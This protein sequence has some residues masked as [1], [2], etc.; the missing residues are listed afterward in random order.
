MVDSYVV[1]SYHK[2]EISLGPRDYLVDQTPPLRRVAW[3]GAGNT[4]LPSLLPDEEMGRLWRLADAT[5]RW[6]AQ[7]KTHK[8]TEPRVVRY[9]DTRQEWHTKA[10]V[11]A[12]PQRHPTP[13]PTTPLAL[14]RVL[15]NGTLELPMGQILDH[16]QQ[17]AEGHS[18][19]HPYLSSG[20]RNIV[21]DTNLP[22]EQFGIYTSRHR[23]DQREDY[24][25]RHLDR[26]GLGAKGPKDTYLFYKFLGVAP[27]PYVVTPVV[28]LMPSHHRPW[29]ALIDR[30]GSY[31]WTIG[32]VWLPLGHL[33]RPRDCPGSLGTDAP[34]LLDRD[35]RD[36]ICAAL[37]S[38][39]GESLVHH[40]T[41]LAE[42][43]YAHPEQ[44]S[45]AQW[46]RLQYETQALLTERL[47]AIY[48]PF[49]RKYKPSDKVE[50]WDLPCTKSLVPPQYQATDDYP[51]ATPAT[52]SQ[53]TPTQSTRGAAT[54]TDAQGGESPRLHSAPSARQTSQ[55]PTQSGGLQTTGRA[56]STDHQRG[57]ISGQCGPT[58]PGK[59]PPPSP[60]PDTPPRAVRAPTH[61]RES[62]G[63]PPPPPGP[64]AHSRR[65]TDRLPPPPPALKAWPEL[66]PPPPRRTVSFQDPPWPPWPVQAAPTPVALS[67]EA[68]QPTPHSPEMGPAT[69]PP[70]VP[71]ALR[72][73]SPTG[74]GPSQTPRGQEHQ[75]RV[76]QPDRSQAP[77]H[78]AVATPGR[79][80]V[81]DDACSTTAQPDWDRASSGTE[82]HQSHT[83]A[84]D[85]QQTRPSRH[86]RGSRHS[87]RPTKDPWDSDEGPTGHTRPSGPE[88]TTA[89]PAPPTPIPTQS[90]TMAFETDFR[91]TNPALARYDLLRQ[92]YLAGRL[93][94]HPP[95]GV[96][97]YNPFGIDLFPV[98]LEHP[99]DSEVEWGIWAVG[100]HH[101]VWV[102]APRHRTRGGTARVYLAEGS[103]HSLLQ[104]WNLC[105]LDATTRWACPWC[106]MQVSHTELHAAEQMAM[107]LWT[108]HPGQVEAALWTMAP[109]VRCPIRNAEEQPPATPWAADYLES[110][111]VPAQV[112]P[113]YHHAFPYP[114]K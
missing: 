82:V 60:A 44:Y 45:Q 51:A 11:L 68:S 57:E 90:F 88:R 66:V 85:A 29:G 25:R 86:G 32:R 75:W 9:P 108:A 58:R 59:P 15:S 17:W 41:P 69:Q 18:P 93:A 6:D 87:H 40:P 42:H 83:L 33:L 8:L 19:G 38:I 112:P 22:P 102:S 3:Q 46:D 71:G 31:T 98:E 54:Q 110:R 43:L 62:E 76:R 114:D 7:A 21:E 106:R 81:E 34:P 64:P 111:T 91:S 70:R 27:L 109:P 10:L 20:L 53:T 50:Y 36:G 28:E 47:D 65:E 100:S 101:P 35:S 84:V 99:A 4:H 77:R 89:A 92:V 14:C 73:H 39:W 74:T 94:D 67:G 95:E 113:I 24:L 61:G 30:T 55:S 96:Y 72:Q 16:D 80:R 79:H 103:V 23:E 48:G 97:T 49:L 1:P 56:G 104:A 63:K 105:L 107:H 2:E 12:S 13:K 52:P 78:A 5:V 37:Q 26:D